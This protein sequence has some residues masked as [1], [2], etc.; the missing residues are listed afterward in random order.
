MRYNLIKS[1]WGSGSI[2]RRISLSFFCLFLT[3]LI[4]I[5]I[6]VYSIS[7]RILTDHVMQSASSDV[8]QLN[9]KVQFILKTLRS[10]SVIVIANDVVQEVLGGT[11][12]NDSSDHERLVAMQ[13]V[14]SQIIEPRTFVYGVVIYATNGTIYT[15]RNIEIIEPEYSRP[16]TYIENRFDDH[17]DRFVFFGTHNNRIT[18]NHRADNVFSVFYPLFN[19]HSGVRIATIELIV[20]ERLL[21][22]QYYRLDAV[23]NR[24]LFITDNNGLII[25]HKDESK[26]SSDISNEPF[27][28]PESPGFNI[29]T[30]DS[31][32][33]PMLSIVTHC[34]VYGYRIYSVMPLESLMVY[35]NRF[36]RNVFLIGVVLL[37]ISSIIV[38][39]LSR[40]IGKP[41]TNLTKTIQ[42][43]VSGDMSTI[44]NVKGKDEIAFL[45]KQYNYLILEVKR[46]IK[47]KGIYEQKKN[48]TTIALIQAQMHPHFLYNSLENLCGLIE[49]DRKTQAVDLVNQLSDFYREV[50][51]KG[52]VIV[53]IEE[54][55]D[56]AQSYV[57]I[58]NHRY[59]NQITLTCEVDINILSF[60]ISKLTFQPLIENSI[61]HG[62]CGQKEKLDINVIGYLEHSKNVVLIVKDNGKGIPDEKKL[63]LSDI[64]QKEQFGSFG[65][66]SVAERLKLYYG[67]DIKFI[68]N[69]ESLVGTEVTIKFRVN[70]F[71]G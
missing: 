33:E 54:D 40:S 10:Y 61:V 42:N 29:F 41:I 3:V 70:S 2:A 1:K 30:F 45:I 22:Q 28:E 19:M 25:S 60:P 32:G 65:L 27:F 43:A 68:I 34:N 37:L 47:E 58:M 69:S 8:I 20:E 71:Q 23:M 39:L 38:V 11:A 55:L 50:L 14:M 9:D 17:G 31:N 36:A 4:T 7:S 66:S 56:I 44:E 53:S 35:T 51:G 6:I 18:K 48:E 62:Y 21:Y 12:F 49:L 15:S 13:R 26:L 57:N 24:E 16:L 64:S 63:G 52:N 5:T 59:N 46:L 67:G